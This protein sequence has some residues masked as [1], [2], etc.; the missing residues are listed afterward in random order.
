MQKNE[1]CGDRTI[2]FSVDEVMAPKMSMIFPDPHTRYLFNTS[3][4]L[5]STM[6]TLVSLFVLLLDRV[7]FDFV[8]GIRKSWVPAG[9]FTS[10]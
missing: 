1:K 3:T 5:M 2:W 10:G 9:I 7:A 4:I 6:R 8:S